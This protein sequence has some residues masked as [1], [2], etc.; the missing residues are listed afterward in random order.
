MTFDNFIIV[1]NASLKL[2][3]LSACKQTGDLTLMTEFFVL[4][5]KFLICNN[6]KKKAAKTHEN[7][8]FLK[9]LTIFLTVNTIK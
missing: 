8:D 5:A 9:R 6:N 4:P 7:R 2:N 3:P 1:T